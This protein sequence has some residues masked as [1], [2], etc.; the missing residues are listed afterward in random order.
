MAEDYKVQVSF[1]FGTNQQ[2]MVNVRGSEVGEVDLLMSEARE[3]LLPSLAGLDEELK[4]AGLIQ[5]TF[6]GSTPMS[7]GGAQ[8]AQSNAA[9]SNGGAPSCV[10]GPRVHRSGDGWQGWF[11][12]AD[13]NDPNKCKPQYIR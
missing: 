13:R 10:H 1:K 8:P 6:P 11:C 7:Q 5:A 4:A 2:G 12:P 9:A 3:V